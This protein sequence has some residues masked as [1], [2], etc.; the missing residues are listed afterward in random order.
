[1]AL[2]L[3]FIFLY[4]RREFNDFSGSFSLSYNMELLS[5]VLK[6]LISHTKLIRI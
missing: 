5:L 2:L 3:W 4:L 1:M 6:K